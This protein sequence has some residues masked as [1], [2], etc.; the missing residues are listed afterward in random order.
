M[1]RFNVSKRRGKAKIK[2]TDKR[3]GVMEK[4]AQNY[5]E[6]FDVQIAVI[7]ELIPLGLHEVSKRLQEE[8]TRLAGKRH[9]RGGDNARW[10]SQNGSVY[11]RDQKFPVKVPR[12]RDTVAQKEVSLET[13]Q[14]L[15]KPFADDGKTVLRLLHGLSTHRYEESSSL[16]A[17]AMGLSA[18]SLSRRFKK[19]TAG[20]LKQFQDRCL[21]G[22]DIIGVFVDG[23][24][25]A[26]DGLMVAMGVT[27]DGRKIFLGVEHIHRENHKAIGQWFEHLV[28]RGLRFEEGILFIMDGSKGIEKAVRRYFEKYAFI[29][30]CQWHKRE[31]VT[32]YLDDMQQELCRRRMQEAYA[33]TT[34]KEAK[35]ELE[36]LHTELLSVNASAANSLAE[37]LEETLTLHRLGL[38]P[39]LAKSL[40]TTNCLESAMSQLGQYTDKVDR[41]HNSDQ[42]LRWSAAVLM[43]MEPRLYK[44]RGFRYLKTLRV[45]MKQIIQQRQSAGKSVKDNSNEFSDVSEVGIA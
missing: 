27:M 20:A 4:I 37:G 16:A 19:S 10:G 17:E 23:K 33:K 15:Q 18:S 45:K 11:L 12:V 1:L 2:V 29:Q 44:I 7:Q 25:Y 32:A 13:Y 43:D 26:D 38:A 6:E 28:A 24:R 42:I 36:K 41:W 3:K 34:Y 40:N 5:S 35:T 8:V 14:G 21:S 31:N 22:Y 39:E 30:R 9:E